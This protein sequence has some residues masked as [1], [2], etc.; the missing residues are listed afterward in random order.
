M[1]FGAILAFVKAVSPLVAIVAS[2]AAAVAHGIIIASH[3]KDHAL[4]IDT[5]AGYAVKGNAA[6]NPAPQ[7]QA[8]DASGTP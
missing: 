4:L 5:I 2:T 7:V 8:T 3:K 6:V 1:D